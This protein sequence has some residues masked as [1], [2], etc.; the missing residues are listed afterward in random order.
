MVSRLA[1]MIRLDD[2]VT[3]GSQLRQ[4]GVDS[5]EPNREATR[6]T[7]VTFGEHIAGRRT[8]GPTTDRECSSQYTM[9][10]QKATSSAKGH[11]GGLSGQALSMGSPPMRNPQAMGRGSSSAENHSN[12]RRPNQGHPSNS[13]ASVPQMT[14][15]PDVYDCA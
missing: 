7:K 9:G 6:E 2:L 15:H 14:D 12:E 11:R 1:I 5:G 8:D 3:S 10:T 13:G 4:S